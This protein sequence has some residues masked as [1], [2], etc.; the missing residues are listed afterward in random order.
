MKTKKL[1]VIRFSSLGDVAL[2]SPVIYAILSKYPD[3]FINLLSKPHHQALFPHHPRLL[4]TG[5]D[6]KNEFKGIRGVFKICR[7]ILQQ[8]F[9]H[10][11]DLHDVL[12]SKLIGWMLKIRG[13][14]VSVFDKGRLEKKAI[15]RSKAPG[16]AAPLKHTT[17]RYAEAFQSTG[18]IIKTKD[19]SKNIL[20]FYGLASPKVKQW[21]DSHGTA[22]KFI[23]IAPLAAHE[24]KI[25]GLNKVAQL[26]QVLQ[27]RYPGAKIFLFG[28][29]EDHAILSKLANQL[30][31]TANLAGMFTL[32]EELWLMNR[33]SV[34]ISMDSA[35]MHLAA[36][37]KIPVISI[38]G[39]THPKMGF[40]PL[41]NEKWIVQK[42][43]LYRPISVFGKVRSKKELKLSQMAMER[44][45]IEDVLE[46]VREILQ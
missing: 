4:F 28:G 35:N 14:T 46:K 31:N 45:Q 39:S 22:T 3:V 42:D 36:L 6:T 34:M 18:I 37:C 19:I 21:F 26:C 15:I 30:E 10:I 12:R 25:W 33:L 27:R 43:L 20:P 40:G 2:L 44:I 38:W 23:G 16:L 13:L 9:D 5:M 41:F 1:L 17:E 29:P 24:S 11:I 8:E 32:E 7:W